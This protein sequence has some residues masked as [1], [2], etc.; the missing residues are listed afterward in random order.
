M[1][2]E[3][4]KRVVRRKVGILW[5]VGSGLGSGTGLPPLDSFTLKSTPQGKI[6]QC[7]CD[8]FILL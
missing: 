5:S 3:M 1:T 7:Q 6:N 4:G 2:L 8:K